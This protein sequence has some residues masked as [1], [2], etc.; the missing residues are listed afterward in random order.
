MCVSNVGQYQSGVALVSAIED[1][2]TPAASIPP[3]AQSNASIGDLAALSS[4]GSSIDFVYACDSGVWRLGFRF[5]PFTSLLVTTIVCCVI[6]V[7]I[8]GAGEVTDPNES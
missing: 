4:L 2:S 7:T 1:N 3:V 8:S 6:N 5:G